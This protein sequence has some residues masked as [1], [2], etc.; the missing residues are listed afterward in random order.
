MPAS[1]VS[2][3]TF[4]VS[5]NSGCNRENTFSV[6]IVSGCY[7]MIIMTIWIRPTTFY[8][9]VPATCYV[10]EG[11]IVGGVVGDTCTTLRMTSYTGSNTGYTL[12]MGNVARSCRCPSF[13]VRI[14]TGGKRDIA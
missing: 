10:A 1:C 4:S 14:M 13:S 11:T 2:M 6:R 9:T 8:V 12:S 3:I 5:T 7:I